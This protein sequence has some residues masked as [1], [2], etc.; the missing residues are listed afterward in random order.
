MRT[1]GA[2]CLLGVL[3]ARGGVLAETVTTTVIDV[4]MWYLGI[5]GQTAVYTGCF[6]QTEAGTVESVVVT[7]L[8]QLGGSDG[9][10]SGI[11][12]DFLLFDTDGVFEGSESGAVDSA[13]L[14]AGDVRRQSTT[15]FKPT[16]NHPYPLFGLGAGGAVTMQTATLNTHD[17]SYVAG[18]NLAVDTCQGWV[19]LGDG[20][21][22]TANIASLSVGPYDSLYLYVGDAGQNDEFIDAQVQIEIGYGS[23]YPAEPGTVSIVLCGALVLLRR[24]T[25]REQHP[26]PGKR[27]KESGADDGATRNGIRRTTSPMS[28]KQPSRGP[29]QRFP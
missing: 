25:Q 15:P 10:F 5:Y 17:A 22:L 8:N 28:C 6:W 27:H 14:S 4:N 9:V 7:D 1:A 23:S 24:H 3:L 20:G 2:I 11:D 21:V 16:T 26:G 29:L 18:Q 12:L 19:S 13:T